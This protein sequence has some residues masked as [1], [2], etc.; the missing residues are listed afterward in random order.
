MTSDTLSS[1]PSSVRDLPAIFL[2][3]GSLNND[4]IHSLPE[5]LEELPGAVQKRKANGIEPGSPNDPICALFRRA[6][7]TRKE[8]QK[9]AFFDESRPYTRNLIATDSETYTLLLLCWNPGQ[10]SP[11]HDHPCDGCWLH[12]LQGDVREC[13]YDQELRCVSDETFN[14]GQLGYIT[15]SMGYHKVGNPTNDSSVTLHLYSPPFQQCRI[16]CSDDAQNPSH[17]SSPNYSEYGRVI[18]DQKV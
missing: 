11:I 12:V 6:R 15:D 7:L 4:L 14:E 13:R 8:W 18:S 3:R 2:E 16:W 17:A 1:S 5:L 10:E 9:Y